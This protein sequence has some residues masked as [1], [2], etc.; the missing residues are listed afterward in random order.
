M[1]TTKNEMPPYAKLFFTK[2]SRYLDN[3]FCE[4]EMIVTE[5]SSIIE[6]LRKQGFNEWIDEEEIINK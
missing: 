3:K 4:R 2:L 5:R 1:E 6:A